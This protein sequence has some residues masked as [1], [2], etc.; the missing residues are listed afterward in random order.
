MKALEDVR[1]LFEND[2]FATE[3]GAVIDEIGDFYAKCSLKL[4]EG[5]K[6]AVGSVMGG[7]SFTLAD[8]A[9]AVASNWQNPGVVSLSSNITYLGTAKGERR[10]QLRK[11]WAYDKLLPCRCTGR[12][13]ESGSSGYGN[14]I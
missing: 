9:F 6:N 7:V 4:T 2:K 5:H 11:K 3:N 10:S 1:K 13:G 12:S 8:F 14:R